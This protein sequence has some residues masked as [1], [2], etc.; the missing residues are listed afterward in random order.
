MNLIYD[1]LHF[2][3][4]PQSGAF[5]FFAAEKGPSDSRF[6]GTYTPRQAG[7]LL[8]EVLMGAIVESP[9]K[10]LIPLSGGLD[11]RALLGAAADMFGADSIRTVTYGS[12]GSLD[13]E[14]G[15]RVADVA[16]VEHVSLD[17]T[18]HPLSYE[19][20]LESVNSSPWTYVPDSYYNRIALE[21]LNP[22]NDSIILSG[23]FG[24]VLTGGH[25]F[26]SQT[27][28]SA[29]S[30]FVLYQKRSKNLTLT[31]NQYEPRSSLPEIDFSSGLNISAALDVAVRQASCIAPIVTPRKHWSSWGSD[32]GIFRPG[33]AKVVAPFADHRWAEYWIGAPVGMLRGQKLY[34]AMIRHRFPKLANVPDKQYVGA[35]SRAGSVMAKLDI[36]SRIVL[37]EVVPSV[38]SR[39]G[40]DFNYINFAS[41]FRER[42]DYMDA[43]CRAVGYLQEK[44]TVSWLDLDSILKRHQAH[45]GDFSQALLLILGLALNLKAEE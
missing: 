14:L 6:F 16:K 1:Y 23:F 43:I 13:Y 28:E 45:E 38:F 36:K 30:D 34:R 9:A 25:K 8:D 26:K 35:R 20:L 42:E 11:S 44:N 37:N 4:L 40:R 31:P 32:M 41:A 39:P 10:I 27:P 33:Q 15:R 29:Y 18:T 22:T 5:D 2:G 12:P 17:L 7:E 21:A 19:A 3:Y 24:D